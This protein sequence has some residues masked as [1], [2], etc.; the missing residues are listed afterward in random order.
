MGF[1]I[2]ASISIVCTK[3]IFI[4]TVFKVR[5]VGLPIKCCHQLSS[6]NL[7]DYC[8]PLKSRPFYLAVSDPLTCARQLVWTL[9]TDFKSKKN[10]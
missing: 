9:G 6:C 8:N 4:E 1:S 2:D 7:S 3:T 5:T 10:H